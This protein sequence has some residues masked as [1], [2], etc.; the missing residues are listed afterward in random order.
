VQHGSVS[1]ST[2]SLPIRLGHHLEISLQVRTF[3]I[4]AARVVAF[5]V[6]AYA[7]FLVYVR[8]PLG[9]LSVAKSGVFGG[10]LGVLSPVFSGLA[11]VGL[12]SATLLQRARVDSIRARAVNV[13]TL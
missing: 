13:N 7:A 8:W 10:S 12:I 11:F 3:A 6:A 9:E 4:L 1:C 2:A 5:S